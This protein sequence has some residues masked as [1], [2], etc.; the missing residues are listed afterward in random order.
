M[1][2][3]HATHSLPAS[4]LGRALHLRRPLFGVKMLNRHQHS[5]A[6]YQVSKWSA[7]NAILPGRCMLSRCPCRAADQPFSRLYQRRNHALRSPSSLA[8]YFS[9]YSY[10]RWGHSSE[11]SP[12]MVLLTMVDGGSSNEKLSNINDCIVCFYNHCTVRYRRSYAGLI[13]YRVK[14]SVTC[15]FFP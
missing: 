7:G 12:T 13:A 2:T 1:S 5:A 4:L 9:C 11:F 8:P 10:V 14:L 3:R 6:L 15:A